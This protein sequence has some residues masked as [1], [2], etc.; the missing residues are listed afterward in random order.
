MST[1]VYP[2]KGMTCSGC[3]NK[4]TSTVTGVDGVTDVDVDIASGELT[5]TSGT[6][7][8]AQ[9]TGSAAHTPAVPLRVVCE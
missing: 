3:L 1:N 5:V 2:V 6:P 9:L 7:I 4:V 8:D